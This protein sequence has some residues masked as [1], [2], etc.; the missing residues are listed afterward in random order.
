[1]IDFGHQNNNL[2]DNN[3]YKTIGV[4]ILF[5]LG[6]VRLPWPI[7]EGILDVTGMNV[8]FSGMG[9]QYDLEGHLNYQIYGADLTFDYLG[10]N[11]STEYVYSDNQFLAALDGSGVII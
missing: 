8:G 11:F 9:G 1:N 6:D 4:R 5:Q 2:A 3:N 10:F 7:P